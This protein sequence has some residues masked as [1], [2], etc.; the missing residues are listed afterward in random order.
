MS[1]L[2]AR[3]LIAAVICAALLLAS[4]VCF[5]GMPHKTAFAAESSDLTD[6]T[7]EENAETPQVDKLVTQ[8]SA[9]VTTYQ[10]SEGQ[11]AKTTLDS[12]TGVKLVSKKPG[13]EANGSDFYFAG[14][15]GYYTGNFEADFRIV[16]ARTATGNFNYG[17]NDLAGSSLD[18]MAAGLNPY[19]D[20]VKATFTFE[21]ANS[22]KQINVSLLSA[23][24]GRISTVSAYV[25]TDTMTVSRATRNSD[26]DALK[27]T[28]MSIG[29]KI[30][31]Q[32]YYNTTLWKTSFTNAF[33]YW[34]TCGSE[35]VLPSVIG[36]DPE[37]MQV[38]GIARQ[39][40]Q[41]KHT[42][43]VKIVILDLDDP[44]QMGG[45]ETQ[46][47]DTDFQDKYTVKFTVDRM[48]PNDTVVDYAD[49]NE[50]TFATTYDRY[51]TVML[52]EVN[53]VAATAATLAE[54]PPVQLN[55]HLDQ[56]EED[57]EMYQPYTLP[58]PSVTLDGEADS[59]EGGT[60]TVTD[61]SEKPVS[62]TD[63]TFTPDQEGAYKVV[64]ELEKMGA[65]STITLTLNVSDMTLPEITFVSGLV[66]DYTWTQDLSV[67]FGAEDVSAMDASG[68]PSVTVSAVDSAN[69]AV[70]SPL[71]KI[72]RYT[73][74]YTATDANENSESITRTITIAD[75]TAPVIADFEFPEKATVGE[76]ITIPDVTA[77]DD[78]TESIKVAFKVTFNE[79][80]IAVEGDTFTPEAAGTY[81]FEWSASDAAGNPI[82]VTKTLVV[83]EESS[84]V[85][86]IVV[87]VVAAV[88]VICAVV[89]VIVIKKKK[90]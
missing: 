9:Q 5:I 20:V 12:R 62:V 27:R 83:G 82:S 43:P 49:Q 53:D 68:T 61:P 36:F 45:W 89:A 65:V 33:S 29:D 69:R 22:G 56:A 39:S 10:I 35:D 58:I 48:T 32:Y 16:S 84:P 2:F 31:D 63:N 67:A 78:V 40:W 23:Q 88:V 73:I 19:A 28:A 42:T 85:V 26:D 17:G 46:F 24:R 37:E 79:E 11:V 86:W 81:T 60:V 7:V 64:Y 1:K 54:Y 13:T 59:F 3:K 21:D 51:A 41:G 76:A 6:W 15:D 18:D 74:T 70:T 34:N 14:T 4:L 47:A 66:N 25:T 30:D 55:L 57:V 50:V 8:S 90:A 71:N 87:G 38:Y 75:N 80:E 72:G 52:Y 44:E 77:S